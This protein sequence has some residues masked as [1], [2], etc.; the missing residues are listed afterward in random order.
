[1]QSE[2]PYQQSR[3]ALVILRGE[4]LRQESLLR[5]PLTAAQTRA[6]FACTPPNSLGDHKRLCPLLGFILRSTNV[7]KRLRGLP[8]FLGTGKR[9]SLKGAKTASDQDQ[10]TS[11]L[12]S[13]EW[14]YMPYT[15]RENS[16]LPNF[17][18]IG[19]TATESDNPLLV[20]LCWSR[21]RPYALEQEEAGS[22]KIRGARRTG[23][24]VF[25]E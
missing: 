3:D 25:P 1:M 24:T 9:G 13:S 5:P 12:L 15:I 21:T 7:R 20:P 22:K 18:L 6:M 11:V 16:M 14:R 17:V 10:E 23:D 8:P 4:L 19:L 2:F